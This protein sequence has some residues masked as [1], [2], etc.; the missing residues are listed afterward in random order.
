VHPVTASISTQVPGKGEGQ[1]H[2]FATL[3]WTTYVTSEAS[4]HGAGANVGKAVAVD[5]SGNIYVT[6]YTDDSTSQ[7]P[8]D[9]TA[10]VAE[11]TN[12]GGQPN[13]IAYLDFEAE[14]PF[15]GPYSQS[16]GNAIAIDSNGGVYVVGTAMSPA[17]GDT[18]AFLLKFTVSADPNH[19]GQNVFTPDP[20]YVGGAIG[21]PYSDTGTSVAVDAQGEATITGTFQ[22]KLVDPTA[23]PPTL[24][25]FD[26]FAAKF[27]ADGKE[28]FFAMY[29]QF[30]LTEPA[31]RSH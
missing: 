9:G 14:D 29:Y 15:L 16:Q 23:T 4:P 27:T 19:P 24:S 3:N 10:F 18:N 11:Y 2:P 28:T 26:I 17:G 20:N 12:A 1:I 30:T 21:G 25:E 13:R 22:S 8:L 6:G 31:T 5:S 7:N